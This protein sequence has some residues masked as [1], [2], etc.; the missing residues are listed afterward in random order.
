M[1]L[2]LQ[3][4]CY[5]AEINL[6]VISQIESSGNPKAVGDGGR[7]LGAFQLHKGVIQD[8]NTAHPHDLKAHSD[9]LQPRHAIR[10]A[11][12][13]LTIRIP[14]M[15]KS[16]GLKDTLENRLWA[17]NAGIVSVKK[18]R[19]PKTTKKYIKKYFSLVLTGD[20]L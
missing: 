10:I 13:Y 3:V 16:K 8:W 18:G 20:F 1:F 2:I 17:Y 6:R 14:K 12:W 9:A 5:A 11:K 19:M 7:A 4:P 15:L